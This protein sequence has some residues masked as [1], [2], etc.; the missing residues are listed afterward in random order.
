MKQAEPR[1]ER[2]V[3]MTRKLQWAEFGEK[4]IVKELEQE[5]AASTCEVPRRKMAVAENEE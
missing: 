3:D 4:I 2:L 1:T 5:W